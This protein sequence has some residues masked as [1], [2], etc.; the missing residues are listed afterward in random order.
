MKIRSLKLSGKTFLLIILMAMLV[1][2]SCQSSVIKIGYRCFNSPQKFDCQYQQFTG[3]EVVTEELQPS[4]NLEL[5][6]EVDVRSG[7]LFIQVI[8]L[9]EIVLWDSKFAESDAGE[10]VIPA[11]QEGLYRMIV[12]GDGTRGGFLIEWSIE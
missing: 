7:T 10:V 9:D 8:A 2:V 4:E 12:Q 3:K 1:M 5:S 11:S 6:Y